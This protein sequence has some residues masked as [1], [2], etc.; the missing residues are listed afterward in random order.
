LGGCSQWVPNRFPNFSNGFFQH[1]PNST[2]VLSHILCP[3]FGPKKW[4]QN[5]EILT[6]LVWDSL[7]SKAPLITSASSSSSSSFVKWPNQ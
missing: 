5:K 7:D 3:K 2:S 6:H 1:V 4:L